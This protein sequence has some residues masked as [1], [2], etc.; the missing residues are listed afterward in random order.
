[1]CL[2]YDRAKP[3]RGPKQLHLIPVTPQKGSQNLMTE[4]NESFRVIFSNHHESG[5]HL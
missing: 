1:M 4:V 2:I 5:I 3:A